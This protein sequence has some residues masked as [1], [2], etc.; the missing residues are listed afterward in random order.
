MLTHVVRDTALLTFHDWLLS[1]L[2]DA[3]LLTFTF[4]LLT[5]IHPRNSTCTD[6]IY[7]AICKFDFPARIL[8]RNIDIIE[9][10]QGGPWEVLQTFPLAEWK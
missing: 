1:A 10:I 3:V 5:L 7:N 2:R 9:Q 4:Y 8:F 6:E